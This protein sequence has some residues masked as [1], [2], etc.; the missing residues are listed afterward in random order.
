MFRGSRVFS[1]QAGH[2]A[3]AFENECF[4][5]VLERGIGWAANRL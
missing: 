1:Y 2:G 4:C 3:S 5:R